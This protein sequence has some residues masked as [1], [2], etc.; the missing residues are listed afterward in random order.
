[1]ADNSGPYSPCEGFFHFSADDEIYRDHF[2]GYPVVPGSLIVNAFLEAAA[3]A[4]F[5]PDNLIV[6]DFSFREFLKPGRYAFRI[7]PATDG[8]HCLIL[9]DGKKLVTG[10][11]RR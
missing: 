6:E 3:V 4:G 1:M 5:L 8:L 11:V 9:R 10:V 7:E 2:P